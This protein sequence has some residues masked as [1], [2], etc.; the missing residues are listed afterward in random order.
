MQGLASALETLAVTPDRLLEQ[1]E[2]VN[3]A[4]QLSVALQ[5]MTRTIQE[6]RLQADQAIKQKADRINEL[7]T[8]IQSLNDSLVAFGTTSRD[9]SDLKDQR[10]QV[11]DELA[12]IV[13]I[14]YFFRANGDIIVF[15]SDGF[16]LADKIIGTVT[17]NAA[18]TASE[19]MT[20]AEGDFDGI[21]VG[22]RIAANDMTTTVR[23]GEI[24]GLVELRDSILPGLQSQLDTFAAKLRDTLNQVH[25]R[26]APFPGL[27]SMTG[28]RIFIEPG[29]QT[30]RL[31][32]T[33]SVDDVT[34]T[35]FNTSGNQTESTTLNTIM[36][37]VTASLA[38][39][40]SRGPWTIN[41]IATKIQDWLQAN[42]AST[43][44]VAVN[45][46]G[47]LAINLNSTTLG[48]AFRDQTATANGST[49][50]DAEIGFDANFDGTVDETVFGFSNFFGLNDFYV[51]GL[52]DN[53]YD[54]D[55]IQGTFSSGAAT[56]VFRDSSGALTGS[57]LTISAGSSL[58]DIADRINNNVPKLSAS[59]IPDGSG[60]R[61]RISHDD[62]SSFTIVQTAGTLLTTLG[63]RPA[64]TRVA[65][66]LAV[67]TDIVQTPSLI[68]R[69]TVQWDSARGATGEYLMS[70][71]DNT[72]VLSLVS[73]A[74]GNVTFKAA[75]GLGASTMSLSNYA[76]Q[77]ISYHAEFI[78]NREI[79]RS[80]SESLV[81]SLQNKSDNER[82]VNLDEEMSNMVLLQQA[83]GASARIFTVIQRMFDALERIIT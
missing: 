59:V 25:N 51:D 6:L 18:A 60:T 74:I 62:G 81:D 61:L 82:G 57:P 21:Y 37:S 24:K 72:N 40:A 42:G 45:T 41:N 17:H 35:L 32:P 28:T 55:V 77:I 58:K 34:I 31:D 30:V 20:H 12:Q 43:A 33:G 7:T 16:V 5:D 49:H 71:G 56:L 39:Q 36:T 44:T 22:A 70:T 11:V 46:A 63:V 78:T 38:A 64:D 19:T 2:V 69:G 54:S 47:K 29:S 10:D 75:G 53:L 15:T 76:V 26:G 50:Q 83:Y 66:A 9:T 3:W 1:S 8:R 52:A 48:L 27:Q 80:F 14:R 79:T 23:G 68:A 73:A 4:Q 67:R 65:G 13:D